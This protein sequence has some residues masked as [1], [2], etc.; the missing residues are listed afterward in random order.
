MSTLTSEPRRPK[1][2]SRWQRYVSDPSIR[3][4]IIVFVASRL[5]LTLWALV[6]LAFRPQPQVPDEVLRPYL[7][8]PR[9]T[10]GVTGA[11]LGPWQ[12]FDT[13]HYMRIAEQGYQTEEDSVFPPLF[14]AAMTGVGALLSPLLP[15]AES[16]LLA[17]II[18]SN[19]A[20]FGVLVLLYRI[21]ARE[22]DD[23]MAL[24]SIIFLTIFPASF[25]LL[26][27]YSESLFI[28]LALGSIFS[29]RSGRFW[30]AGSLGLL[31]SLTR[32]TGVVL[33]FPLA[34]EYLYRRDFKIS[35]IDRVSISIFLPL[36]GIGGFLL[37]RSYAGLPP[38]NQIYEQYWY[39]T[40]GFP[41]TDMIKAVVRVFQGK[42]AFT[43]FFDF[44]CALLLIVTTIAAFRSLRPTF[45]L[46]SAGLLLF[47]LLP[48]SDLKPLF[49]FSRY[50]L[51]FFP[52]FM[53]MS[54][55]AATPWR[56]RIVIYPSVALMLYFSGQFIMWGWVA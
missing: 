3:Y 39:Q 12:R 25:F 17:A 24:R 54:Q 4:A 20:F 31:A 9:F 47:I 37:W 10:E 38:L 18:V 56:K 50:A 41:G 48:T 51:A 19:I 22:L 14:P 32:L 49:S 36:V 40:T 8:Q 33:L 1:S 7:G 11:F 6:V 28:F 42:A 2:P 27:A 21:T 5:F 16:S 29:A 53:I 35:K 55:F 45:G 13:L 30:L 34:Y 46:Y 23:D 43:L 44:F 15:Q 26:A 52:T